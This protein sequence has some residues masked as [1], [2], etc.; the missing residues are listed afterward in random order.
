MARLNPP[1]V[2]MPKVT[3][4]GRASRSGSEKT[5]ATKAATEPKDAANKGND[6]TPASTQA[7]EATPATKPAPGAPGA[8]SPDP[9]LQERMEG[10][11]GWMAELERKQARTT[12]FG[13]V[14]ILIAIGAAG[15]ALYFGITNKNDSAT[16]DDVDA[17][18]SRVDA[19]QTAV[20]KN[21]KNTQD[22]INNSIAQLQGSL[23]AL[24]KQQAQNAATIS[25]LQTQVAQ[26]ALNNKAGNAAGTAVTPGTTTTTPKN[27]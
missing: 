19:L 26:G 14:A 17:L 25:T 24:Q 8:K 16:K 6:T 7:K 13:A 11:Q 9:N 12:Y 20:T 1:R 22:A 23:Q 3:L 15:A 27:P 18:K 21:S 10:L 5:T 4:P 2:R